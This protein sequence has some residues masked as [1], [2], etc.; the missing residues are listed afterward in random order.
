[1]ASLGRT[2]LYSSTQASRAIWLAA[3]P[4][5]ILPSISRAMSACMRSREPFCPGQPGRDLSGRIPSVIH[6][7][8]SLVRPKMPLVAAKGVPLSLWIALGSPYLRNSS[9]MIGRTSSV[10]LPV[11]SRAHST[12]REYLSRTVKG[13]QRSLSETHQPLKSMHQTS[14]GSWASSI[15]FRRGQSEETLA[16]WI[17]FFF[18]SFAFSRMR[19]TLDSDGGGRLG[20]LRCQSTSSFFP[21]Q[22]GWASRNAISSAAVSPSMV[23]GCFCGARDSSSRPA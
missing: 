5:G 4:P 1:M 14:L 13:S 10:V 23:F 8:D 17:R 15:W 11:I 21:P 22:L 9:V 20:W 19:L 12:F 3:M 16:L 18:S 7:A 2:A 6:Q